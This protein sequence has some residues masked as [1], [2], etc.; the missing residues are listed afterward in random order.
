MALWWYSNGVLDLLKF[1][2]AFYSYIEGIFSI[3]ILLKTL[4]APWK[5]LVYAKRPGLEGL[6]DWLLDNFISRSVGFLLRLTIIFIFLVSTIFFL[7]FSVLAVTFW[8]GFPFI[9]VYSF[10]YIFKGN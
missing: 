6:R 9:L 3:K 8:I 5:R 4:F 1:L 7:A 10:I 2:Q